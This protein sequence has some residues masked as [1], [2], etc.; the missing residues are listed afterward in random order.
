MGNILSLIDTNITLNSKYIK[1]KIEV[2]ELDFYKTQYS[3]ELLNFIKDT[4]LII[5]AD[6]NYLPFSFQVCLY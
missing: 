3:E 1:G 5:A 4:T 2:K 6:G